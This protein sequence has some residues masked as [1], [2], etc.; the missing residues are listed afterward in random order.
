M[1]CLVLASDGF[2]R[3]EEAQAAALFVK[4]YPGER[5]TA[6]GGPEG[7][8]IIIATTGRVTKPNKPAVN[9]VTGTLDIS[10]I[11]YSSVK[12]VFLVGGVKDGAKYL[13]QYDPATDALTDLSASVANVPL[14]A[15]EAHADGR[16]YIGCRGGRVYAYDPATGVFT[17]LSAVLGFKGDVKSAAWWAPFIYLGSSA[18]ELK[19]YNVLTGSVEDLTAALGASDIPQLAFNGVELVIICVVAGAKKVYSYDGTAFTDRTVALGYTPLG[20]SCRG[21]KMLFTTAEGRVL[22]LTDAW[23][24]DK[25]LS[26]AFGYPVGTPLLLGEREFKDAWASIPG[27]VPTDYPLSGA[28]TIGN[29]IYIITYSTSDYSIK[30]HDEVD[31]RTLAKAAKATATFGAYGPSKRAELGGYY[32]AM[33]DVDLRRYDPAADAW[34]DLA[35]CGDNHGDWAAMAGISPYVFVAG[36]NSR[37]SPYS[38]T[39][40][41]RYDPAANAWAQVASMAYT[42]RDVAQPGRGLGG[43]LY[44]TGGRDNVPDKPLTYNEAYDPAADAWSLRAALPSRRKLHGCCP[45]GGLLYVGGGNDEVVPVLSDMMRYDPTANAWTVLASMPAPRQAH[46]LEPFQDL[47]LAVGGHDG[48]TNVDTIL[49][50][51][52]P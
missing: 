14:T 9:L 22:L 35:D 2:L 25:D 46:M 17:D 34:T 29:K 13:A 38:T 20:V 15:A 33:A 24:L 50:Y 49:V 51:W 48:T 43:L 27:V 21:G 18:G 12:A 30:T 7:G 36:G 3:M 4:A 1:Y 10:L 32:Y 40:C 47:I 42:R 11:C 41:D 37:V 8:N 52:P 44:A 6:M 31:P 23:A 19:R 26:E 16:I 28:L 45:S 39:R 5:V